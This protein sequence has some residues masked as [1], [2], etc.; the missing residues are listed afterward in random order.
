MLRFHAEVTWSTM[1]TMVKIM[2]AGMA[3]TCLG[4]TTRNMMTK[5]TPSRVGM[6]YKL[7]LLS[8]TFDTCFFQFSFVDYFRGYELLFEPK[9]IGIKPKN[10]NKVV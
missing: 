6:R 8:S 10:N 3:N 5:N 2:V 9:V 7:F 1:E 4:F